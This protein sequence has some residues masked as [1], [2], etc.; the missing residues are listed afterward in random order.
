MLE[1]LFDS[2]QLLDPMDDETEDDY[3]KHLLQEL[4]RLTLSFESGEPHY[5]EVEGEDSCSRLYEFLESRKE[6][7]VRGLTFLSVPSCALD[8]DLEEFADV[9]EEE[10]CDMCRHSDSEDG[11]EGYGLYSDDLDYY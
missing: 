9:V 3:D 10:T 11:F 1:C 4:T 7:G 2:M 6:A 5:A 8:D